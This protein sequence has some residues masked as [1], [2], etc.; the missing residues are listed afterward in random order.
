MCT[1]ELWPSFP[2]TLAWFCTVARLA[3]TCH[4]Y[5]CAE[6]VGKRHCALLRTNVNSMRCACTQSPRVPSVPS[7]RGGGCDLRY[8]LQFDAVVRGMRAA[9][10]P[11]AMRFMGLGLQNAYNLDW[12]ATFLNRSCHDLEDPPLD[13][14]SFHFYSGATSRTDPTAY[15]VRARCGCKRLPTTAAHARVGACWV[16]A[17]PAASHA[18]APCRGN[19]SDSVD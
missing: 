11:E 2:L 1:C 5:A 18:S 10:A 3:L 12:V 19:P 4:Q 8:T 15:E 9:G 6:L 17:A 14:A 13:A 7:P 16:H